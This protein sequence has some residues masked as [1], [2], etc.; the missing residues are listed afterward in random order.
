MG[1][2]ERQS[3]PLHGEAGHPGDR[4][5]QALRWCPSGPRYP[6]RAWHLQHCS[7]EASRVG[8]RPSAPAQAEPRLEFRELCA[9]RARAW[10]SS[11]LQL[12]DLPG[13][14]LPLGRCPGDG[15]WQ[16]R[17]G[18]PWARAPSLDPRPALEAAESPSPRAQPQ[19][20]PGASGAHASQAHGAAPLSAVL[21][22]AIGGSTERPG[23]L[24]PLPGSFCWCRGRGGSAGDGRARRACAAHR[25]RWGSTAQVRG[26][27]RCPAGLSQ[28]RHLQG[29][30][31]RPWRTPAPTRAIGAGAGLLGGEATRRAY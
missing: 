26:R 27:G 4:R 18:A 22:V 19:P 25:A 5:L 15:G 1:G 16:D 11:R 17:P 21:P 7:T 6:G 20:Q 28:V 9:V 23:G 8:S 30:G 12:Q 3:M 2:G 13:H 24:A 14:Q 31:C 29:W 10:A